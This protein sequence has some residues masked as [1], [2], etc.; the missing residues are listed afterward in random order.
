MGESGDQELTL[1]NF[2][3]IPMKL[4][5]VNYF[6]EM[7]TEAAFGSLPRE[8]SNSGLEPKSEIYVV[9]ENVCFLKSF[10]QKFHFHEKEKAT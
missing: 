9:A 7:E 10:F 8:H 4:Q 6:S 1:I 3:N 2:Y 5:S